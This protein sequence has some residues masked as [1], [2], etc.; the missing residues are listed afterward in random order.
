MLTSAMRLLARL[1]PEMF[2]YH[3]NWKADATHPAFITRSATL[4]HVNPIALGGDPIAED[5][6]CDGVLGMQ[7]P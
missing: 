4:D 2:P 7:P 5:K 3:Q 6:S 1:F